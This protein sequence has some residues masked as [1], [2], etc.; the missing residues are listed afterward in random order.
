M[1][2]KSNMN[3]VV[4]KDVYPPRKEYLAIK[5]EIDELR[6]R[7]NLLK[8]AK[9]P[10]R[11]LNLNPSFGGRWVIDTGASDHFSGMR[12]LFSNFEPCKEPMSSNIAKDTYLSVLGIGSVHTSIATLSPVLYVENMPVNLLSV[13]SL[14]A[15]LSCSVTF[16]P[17]NCLIQDL[18]TDEILGMGYEEDGLYFLEQDI[19][20]GFFGG[21]GISKN[22]ELVLEHNSVCEGKSRK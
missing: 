14:T 16:F 10:S 12:Q 15:Q 1:E 20:K 19:V 18:M 8:L 5:R 9:K 22:N 3:C 13:S 7:K 2:L 17:N 6:G 21:S 11:F 4:R